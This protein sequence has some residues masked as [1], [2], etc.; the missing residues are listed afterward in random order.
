[1]LN[2]TSGTFSNPRWQ[3]H[4]SKFVYTNNLHCEWKIEATAGL[5]IVLNIT[6]ID[7]EFG[8]DCMNDVLKV[9][10]LFISCIIFSQ[11]TIKL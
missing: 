10:D 4:G 11:F 9:C 7:I 6:N 1:V 5:R 8:F 2:D 3:V